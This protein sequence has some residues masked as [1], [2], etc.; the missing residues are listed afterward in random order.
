MR[1]Y[2][3]WSLSNNS[4]CCR[5]LEEDFGC[6][7]EEFLFFYFIMILED[8]RFMI[9]KDV[10]VENNGELSIENEYLFN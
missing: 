6:F 2:N 1:F 9:L 8:F 3:G 5:V 10:C 7:E 4:I